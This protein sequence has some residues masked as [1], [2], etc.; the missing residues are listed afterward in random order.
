MVPAAAFGSWHWSSPY[1]VCGDKVIP[2][3]GHCDI[4]QSKSETKH[5]RHMGY[6]SPRRQMMHG[7]SAD[8]VQCREGFVLMMRHSGAAACLTQSTAEKLEM[9]GWGMPCCKPGIVSTATS[10]AECVAQGNPVMESHPRQC[11]TADGKHFVE[12]INIPTIEN[13]PASPGTVVNFYVTD[14]DLN[15]S[16]NG[17][18]TIDTAGLIEATVNGIPI[19]IPATMTETAPSSG[20]FFLII[21][22]PDTINGVP[23]SQDDVVLVRY[24]DQSDYS[25][26]PAVI[27]ESFSLGKTFAKL[28]TQTKQRIGHEFVFRVFEQDANRDSKNEDKIPL[29]AIEFRAEGGIRTTLANPVFDANSS[30]LL[31]TGEN[32]GVFEVTIKIPRTID[33]DTVHIGDWFEFRYYDASTPSDSIE[34]IILKGTI[35]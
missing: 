9:R 27:E 8:Q 34:K 25:G 11:R 12:N 1:E 19:D 23:L 29:S 5:Q 4:G 7:V 6:D 14:D 16:Q 26:N 2:K 13:I 22:L 21:Q 30:Y 17:I 18:D 15:T 10:F 28:Q 33:G 20:K 3:G 35:G 24:L 31:E 32:T